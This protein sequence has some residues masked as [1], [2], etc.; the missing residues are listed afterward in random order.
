MMKYKS[1]MLNCDT[2][3]FKCHKYEVKY[4]V[5]TPV[6]VCWIASKGWINAV[7]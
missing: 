1:M 5:G 2:K 3:S 4:C 6:I 7:C